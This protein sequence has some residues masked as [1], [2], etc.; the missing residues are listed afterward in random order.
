MDQK[1]ILLDT[2]IYGLIIVDKDIEEVNV[3]RLRNK[4]GLIIYGVD[5]IRKELRAIPKYLKYDGRKLRML[6]L[7]LYDNVVK[8]HSLKITDNIN[9]I[10][11]KYFLIYKKLGGGVSK[12]KIMTDFYIIAVASVKEMDIVVSDDHK[13]MLSNNAT[14]AYEIVNELFGLRTPRLIGYEK[15]KRWLV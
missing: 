14:K 1:K 7:G 9:E 2:N 13:T 6:V 3:G 8:S 15:F 5:I 11:E 4:N 10:G 12:D